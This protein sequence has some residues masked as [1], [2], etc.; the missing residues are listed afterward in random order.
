MALG[1]SAPE[2][3]L[4]TIETSGNL[5]GCPGELGA[6]TIV[7]SAAFN[8]LVIT[9]A[10]VYAV[11][12]E[13]D[14]DPDRDVSVPLGYKKIYDMG[15]FTWTASVSVFAYV[16]LY[17]VLKDQ[18]VTSVEAWLTFAYFFIFVAVAFMFDKYNASKVVKE[19]KDEQTPLIEFTAVEIYRELIDDKKGIPAVSEEAIQK[20]EKMKSFVKETMK[21]D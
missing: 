9:A 5:G 17:I 15:V 19:D 3:L 20:R 8:L 12:E 2:I 7:G 14:V 10:C 21:T 6:S 11:N 18:M 16:W 4:A 1:S 13:N